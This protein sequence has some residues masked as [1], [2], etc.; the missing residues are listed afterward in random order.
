MPI[1]SL[2]EENFDTTIQNNAVVV[3]DFWAK[4]CG[5][6]VAFSPIFEEVS[7][8]H[9]DVLFA[10]VNIEEAPALAEDFNVQSIP[11][12]MIFRGEFAVFAQAGVQTRRSLGALVKEAKEIDLAALR[13]SLS[14][15]K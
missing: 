9:P 8:D 13:Q 15:D 4:W 6:C 12:I 10:K 3:V 7:V 5:P 11:F 2:S 1:L 14:Q